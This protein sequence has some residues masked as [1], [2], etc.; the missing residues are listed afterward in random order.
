MDEKSATENHVVL[1]LLFWAYVLIPLG[2]G[3]FQTL[4]KA[5]ALFH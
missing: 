3:V 2:W 1:L 4:K 5:L